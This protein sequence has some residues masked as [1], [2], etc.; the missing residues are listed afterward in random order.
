[1]SKNRERVEGLLRTL[2]ENRFF[3]INVKRVDR[4]EVGHFHA[5]VDP[6]VR[7]D[8]LKAL[9]DAGLTATTHGLGIIRVPT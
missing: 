2:F 6:G 5:Y 3:G 1:M 9:R 7:E 4:W 8:A